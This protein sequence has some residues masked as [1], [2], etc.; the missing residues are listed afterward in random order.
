MVGHLHLNSERP[1]RKHRSNCRFAEGVVGRQFIFP[2][3][4]SPRATP[5]QLDGHGHT[6]PSRGSVRGSPKRARVPGT[7]CHPRTVAVRT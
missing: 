1:H 2:N 4:H 6:V 5:I 7:W 3:Y